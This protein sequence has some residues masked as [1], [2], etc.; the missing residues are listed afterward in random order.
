MRLASILVVALTGAACTSAVEEP[1]GG[2]SGEPLVAS[3]EVEVG[4]SSARLLLHVTNSGSEPVAFTFP[5]AQRHDLVVTTREGEEVWRW[6]N[7]MA[8]AQVVSRA[9]LQPGE[10]WGMSAVWE[11]GSRTGEYVATGV[12]AASDRS[13]RQSVSFEI[14]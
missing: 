6:S 5:T 2:A 10:T 14:R 7:G 9:T 4:P 1:G 11:Y 13:L 12:L 8:F 3:V